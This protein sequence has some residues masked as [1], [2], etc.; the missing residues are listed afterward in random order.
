MTDPRPL[1]LPGG[2]GAVPVL[3]DPRDR[4]AVAVWVAGYLAGALLRA[5]LPF[6]SVSIEPHRADNRI[7]PGFAAQ[8]G[9]VALVIHVDQAIP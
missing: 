5:G 2:L 7:Q 9:D 3:V 6:D 1:E 8:L 4:E